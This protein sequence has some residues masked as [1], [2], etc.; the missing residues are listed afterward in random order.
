MSMKTVL[1]RLLFFLA[2][3][4]CGASSAETWYVNGG[5]TEP[6]DGLSLETG[7]ETIQEGIDAALDGDTV[8]VAE[9]TYLENIHFKG[10]N[11][12]LT[13]TDPLDPDVVAT[14]IVDGGQAGSVVTFDG[15]ED[16]TCLLSG[17]TIRNG[18]GGSGGGICGR[19]QEK[20]TEATIENN[21]I[22][23]N[24]ADHG[25]GLAYCNGLIRGNT[26]SENTSTSD[27]GGVYRCGGDIQKNAIS[28]NTAG[29]DGGGLSECNGAVENN[30]I[31]GN[32]AGG[33][34]GGLFGCGGTIRDNTIS[35]N[36]A[37]GDGAGLFGC[38][39]TIQN[40]MVSEN[41]ADG[42]GGGLSQCDGTI[43]KNAIIG[44][45]AERFGG[46]AAYCDGL[47]D[48]NNITGNSAHGGGGLY[49]CGGTIQDNT[50][51][52]NSAIHSLKVSYGGG[53]YACNGT[54]QNNVIS[55]NSAGYYGGGLAFCGGTI[56][57]NLI[58]AN[59][60]IG[61]GR[62][63]GLAYCDGTMQNNTI[64]G[65]SAGLGGGLDFCFGEIRDCIIWG[66]TATIQASQVGAGRPTYSCIQDWA[67]GGEGNITADPRFVDPD[68][69]DDD[70]QTYEDN[71]YRLRSDSPCINAG[72]DYYWFAW[73]QRDQDGN[74]RLAGARVDMGCYEYGSSADSD[75]D[76]LSDD[77]EST[78]ETSPESEDTDGDGLRDGLEVLRGS[79]PLSATLPVVVEVA[80][81]ISTIQ[82]ALCLAVN[83]DEIVVGPGTYSGNLCFCGADVTLRSSDPQ[84]PHIVASTI[85]DG[86]GIGPVVSFAGSESEACILSGFTIRNGDTDYGGGICGRRVGD[87]HTHATIENNVIT[88]NYAAYIDGE[89]GGGLWACDGTI[90]NNTISNN[91]GAGLLD[92][93]G[94]IQN[95]TISGNSAPYRGG[96]LYDCDGTIQNNTISG[97]SARFNG[98]GLHDC[99][100]TIRSNTI[101]GNVALGV[102]GIDGVGGGLN[103]CDGIVQNNTIAG[104]SAAAGGG[105]AGCNGT[106]INCIVWGNTAPEGAQLYDSSEPSYSCIEG[107]I[108][109]GE[110]N[111]SEDPQFVDP[112]GRDDDPETYEDNDYRLLRTS[113]CI[114]AG[115]NEEWMVGAVDLDGDPRILDG[116]VDMGAYEGYLAI[117]YVDGA[118]PESG[119]GGSWERAFKTVQEG[120][121]AARAGDSVVV[122]EGTYAE[123]IQFNGRDITLRSTDPSDPSV[124]ASTIIVDAGEQGPVVTFDGTETPNCLLLGFTIRNGSAD[125]GGGV[126]GGTRW[127]HTLATIRNNTI[128]GNSAV[129]DGGGIAFCDGII[130]NNMIIENRAR[131][132]GG[133]LSDC[134]GT[135]LN[136]TIAD[137]SA[138]YSGGGAHWCHGT[139]YDNV[140][141]GNSAGRGGGL[142]C[143]NGD[144]ERNTITGNSAILGGGGLA[145]C[146]GTVQYN[147][148]MTN[149][150]FYGGGL[151]WGESTIQ[152]NLIVGNWADDRGGGLEG[153]DGIIGNNT[154]VDNAAPDRGGGLA[155]CDATILNCIIWG[156]TA[157]YSA[158]LSACS[159]PTYCCI[160]ESEEGEG[161]FSES[162]Q[163]VD[164]DGP[165]DDPLTYE[166]NNYRLSVDSP[167]IDAGMNEEWMWTAVDMEGKLRILFGASSETVDSGAYEY[168][169]SQL[170][171][172]RIFKA[173]GGVLLIWEGYPGYTYTIWSCL[174]L[175][176][177]EW[178]EET[179]VSSTG[180]WWTDLDTDHTCKFYRIELK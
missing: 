158:Q 8:I 122:T 76:L 102:Y 177:G 98:G 49:D 89:G 166:D 176:T 54:I 87:S 97:N 60:V 63:G 148:I 152:N 17:F 13:S 104:N 75:G 137:N 73:P 125:Y 71:D 70:P 61:D 154:I 169:V 129:Y 155:D 105:L 24:Q 109:A 25:A 7:F 120:I 136:N 160:Q 33:H 110:G 132:N 34:G 161:N 103:E 134:Q 84:D 58:A 135:I 123:N 142:D 52:G 15:T 116:T 10:K 67:R 78:A 39:G 165:D 22:R 62:G 4:Y 36:T 16:E 128:T 92:C 117:W 77:G 74:C 20:R 141:S 46:G 180:T 69:P 113:P 80:P 1:F 21:I 111:I 86:G 149:S 171:S 55:G 151:A 115:I 23:A 6:R 31:S 12:I 95:N 156:N 147:L 119:D 96:G 170:T 45:S 65:N 64:V 82:R 59:N 32:S 131:D 50:I 126:C 172:L 88:A 72:V 138:F 174:D 5:A 38:D 2:L 133:G 112:D 11:I 140:V 144:I 106:I 143:C 26:I 146:E 18:K 145:W 41:W 157:A 162:P 101:T 127:R 83:G 91:R 107:W 114:D 53:L 27:G 42:S 168:R 179:T 94:T 159:E 118:V 51:T 164:P 57:N 37:R 30:S 47:M 175:L 99:D 163:F 121:A 29:S 85:L 14:T 28:D 66:N 9:G 108:G 90:Q 173:W 139:I 124:V 19:T 48:H 81:G 56:Q 93:D 130:E 150:A 40:N 178:I 3:S 43:Q 100:G 79:D 35:Q 153:C 44:N 68:G 167:C